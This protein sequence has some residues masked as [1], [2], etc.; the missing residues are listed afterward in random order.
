MNFVAFKKNN[1]IR[2]LSITVIFVF[3][4]G[5]FLEKDNV[6]IVEMQNFQQYGMQSLDRY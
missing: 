1:Q 2:I 5:I 3:F 4:F 6:K